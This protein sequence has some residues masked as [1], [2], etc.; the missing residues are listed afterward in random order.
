[1]IE[2]RQLTLCGT[3]EASRGGSTCAH[4]ALQCFEMASVLDV[5]VQKN[6]N[7]C[8]RKRFWRIL[9]HCGHSV[10]IPFS[11]LSNDLPVKNHYPPFRKQ[12]A[13]KIVVEELFSEGL[14]K[15]V[16]IDCA[17][18]LLG[19]YF[20]G[21][22]AILLLLSAFSLF[23]VACFQ[24]LICAMAILSLRQSISEELFRAGLRKTRLIIARNKLK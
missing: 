19:N 14:R 9:G 7:N 3:K 6:I 10:M 20:R 2:N 1:M 24:E 12:C 4:F 8:L 15:I 22:C 16:A 11:G 23:L 17:K 13:S 18:E 5:S 21:E